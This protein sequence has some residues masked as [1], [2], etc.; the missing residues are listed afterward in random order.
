MTFLEDF[1]W[2]SV[3]TLQA[4]SI[5]GLCIFAMVF[6]QA[7]RSKRPKF[8][9]W[10]G[11][12]VL[13]LTI[14]F[15]HEVRFWELLGIHAEELDTFATTVVLLCTLCLPVVL[16]CAVRAYFKEGVRRYKTSRR[17]DRHYE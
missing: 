13:L 9:S 10:A 17:R 12:L 7:L 11:A 1:H 8:A 4:I 14:T 5:L 3:N 16:V 15:M 2:S 6:S